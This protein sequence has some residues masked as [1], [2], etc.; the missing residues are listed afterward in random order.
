MQKSIYSFIA[1]LSMAHSP[2]GSENSIFFCQIKN[3]G[4]NKHPNLCIEFI[5]PLYR[6]KRREPISFDKKK[7]SSRV[8][9]EEFD[10]LQNVGHKVG[11]FTVVAAPR[12]FL[13]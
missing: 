9:L 13:F 1:G 3:N 2:F 5:N 8:S 7:N 6:V 12:I 4:I 10:L 11:F